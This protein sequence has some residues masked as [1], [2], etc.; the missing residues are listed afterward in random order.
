MHFL[1]QVS[2]VC[3]K[4]YLKKVMKIVL[5]ELMNRVGLPTGS[6]ICALTTYM[7]FGGSALAVLDRERD[8]QQRWQAESRVLTHREWFCAYCPRLRRDFG[9]LGGCPNKVCVRGPPIC[10]FN[11]FC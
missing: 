3:Q 11:L 9:Y 1:F 8:P 5:K 7:G 6:L 2:S 4:Q 10:I